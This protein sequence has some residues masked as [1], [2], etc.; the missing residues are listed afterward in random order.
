[1]RRW[2]IVTGILV[3]AC[4]A[5]VLALTQPPRS[6]AP[7]ATSRTVHLKRLAVTSFD[8]AKIMAICDRL[9]PDVSLRLSKPTLVSRIGGVDALIFATSTKYSACLVSGTKN[10]DENQPTPFVHSSRAIHELESFAVVN[11]IPGRVLYATN[12]WFVVRVGPTVSTIKAV[13]RSLSQVSK[14]GD[15]FAFVHV[16]ETADLRGKFAYGV[17][18]GFSAGGELVGSATLR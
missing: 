11:K 2:Y 15:G 7:S 10:V 18:A 9:N 3:L 8:D 1:M 5:V 17:A 4:V 16:K 13:M 6:V 14:I 12:T